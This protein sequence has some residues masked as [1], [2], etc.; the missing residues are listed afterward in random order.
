MCKVVNRVTDLIEFVLDRPK[1]NGRSMMTFY[2]GQKDCHWPCVPSIGRPPFTECAIYK[3]EERNRDSAEW[4]FFARF[5]DLSAS[6]EPSWVG[7][8]TPAE[9]DWRRVI[10]ARHHGVPTRL[11]DWTSRPL[12]AL[13]FAVSGPP[14]SCSTPPCTH[15]R[16]RR[17]KAHDSA[18]YVLQEKRSDV[19]TLNGLARDN[20]KA[21]F[22]GGEREVGVFIPPTILQ[23]VTAQG[24]VFSVSRN[25][26]QPV[27]ARPEMIVPAAKRPDLLRQL[28]DL[29]VTEA[30]LFPDLDGIGRWLVADSPKWGCSHGVGK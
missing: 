21:P 24:S 6:L 8:G 10:L 28:D 5:R 17:R 1:G 15:C 9:S 13:Y 20:Q 18:I 26:L 12:V 4:L 2:R 27:K 23:R 3:G 25:P 30:S 11:L 16:S 29:G 22:Y 19:F 7:V 14:S